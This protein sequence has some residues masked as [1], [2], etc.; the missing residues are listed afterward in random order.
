[1]INFSCSSFLNNEYDEA[2][3][4][5]KKTR[6]ITKMKLLHYLLLGCILFQLWLITVVDES[7]TLLP[8]LIND[9]KIPSRLI[10]VDTRYNILETRQPVH[11]YRNLQ[12]TIDMYSQ[13]WKHTPQE[14]DIMF[15]TDQPCRKMIQQVAPRL[16]KP[17]ITEPF[18]PFKSDICRLAAVYIHG[19]YYFDSDAQALKALDPSPEIDFIAVDT[20][21][22]FFNAVI[23]APPKHPVIRAA[24][25][26]MVDD[27]YYNQALFE[28]FQVKDFDPSI[29]F[30]EHYQTT[31]KFHEIGKIMRGAQNNV[32]PMTL[33][34]GY[35]RRQNET[36]AWILNEFYNKY[37]TVYPSLERNE[38]GW[39]G[40]NFMVHDEVIKTAYFYSRC[41][42]TD[43]CP[44]EEI[45][46][47]P[48]G[49]GK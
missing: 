33:K 18:G 14:T 15:F 42:G 30:T 28:R 49:N 35:Q 37:P 25:D 12:N 11:L 9:R 27:W 8:A 10:F 2:W 20:G 5:Q 24:L 22:D 39:R 46:R 32:G 47:S 16:L 21:N 23:A 44:S 13:A 40:C 17:Y 6:K 29:F 48:K 41:I 38:T 1:M 3:Q 7:L 43:G 26:S 45:Q 19:G 4:N 34:L 31:L 36:T